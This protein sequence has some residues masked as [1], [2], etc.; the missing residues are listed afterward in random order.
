[1]VRKTRIDFVNDPVKLAVEMLQAQQDSVMASLQTG[2]K[3]SLLRAA[4]P[5]RINVK[6]FSEA[7][8]VE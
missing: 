7:M 5:K 1:M 6:D 8:R 4:L 2:R 3:M